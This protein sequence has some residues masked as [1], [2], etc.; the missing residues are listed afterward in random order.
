M[1]PESPRW[2]A[3][4][5][6]VEEARAFLVKYHAGGDEDSTLANFEFLEIVNSLALEAQY[7]R[8]SSWLDLFRGRGNLHRPFISVTLGVFAQWNG[9]GIVSYY[10]APVL[11]SVGITSVRD[12]TMISGFLQLWNLILAIASAFNVDR[13]GRRPLFLVSSVGILASYIVISGLPGSFAQSGT[14]SI[15]TAVIPFLCIYYSFY[16]IAFTPLLVSYT[17]EIWPYNVRAWGLGLGMNNTRIALFF[18]TFV[19]PIILGVIAWKYYIVYCVLLVIISVTIC[20]W[21]PETKGYTLEEMAVLFDGDR[22]G[23]NL[24]GFRAESAGEGKEAGVDV[25]HFEKV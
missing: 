17:C 12:Q 20:S 3:F 25:S 19:N 7:R 16:D 10:L 2:L 22:K 5:E 9:V 13:F 23:G 4:K 15:G 1:A 21:Y 18:N 11:R 8:S 24:R 6:R 14:S